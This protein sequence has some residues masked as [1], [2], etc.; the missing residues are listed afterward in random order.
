MAALSHEQ[1]LDAIAS[2]TVLEVSE[3]VKAMEEKFGVSAAA[4]VAIA[5]G[6]GGGAVAEPVEE[7]TEFNVILKEFAADKKI[8]VIKEIRA[9]TGLGLKEAKDLVEG[10]PK[11]V[12]ENVAKAEADKIKEQLVAAGA[13]VEIQ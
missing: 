9:I 5:V 13:T 10:A 2:M 3:L 7:K 1:I 11:T 4:P 6:G 12:K 8:G